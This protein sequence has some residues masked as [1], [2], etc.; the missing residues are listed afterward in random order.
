M[1]VKRILVLV[2]SIPLVLSLSGCAT[3][4][5]QKDLEIQRLRGQV[6][7]LEVQDRT[8]DEEIS[9][10]R[11]ELELSRERAI[12]EIKSRP[13][14]KQIQ[15]ALTNAG[16]YNGAIDGKIGSQTRQAIKDFQKANNITEDG[17]VGK[18]TWDLL[19]KYLYE[20]VK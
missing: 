11:N 5:K 7:V 6:S 15:I 18:E 2:L 9:R 16:N 1:L 8:K 3:G 14:A 13:N 12:G 17:K 10:L 4:R 20:K 19:R